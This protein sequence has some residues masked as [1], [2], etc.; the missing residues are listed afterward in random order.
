[1]RR[2]LAEPAP[3]NRR[4]PFVRC[5]SDRIDYKRIAL[6]MTDRIT[7]R[8]RIPQVLADVL[9][10]LE[11]DVPGI[12]VSLARDDNAVFVLPDVDRPPWTSGEGQ[13]EHV[14]PAD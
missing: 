3:W 1:M 7:F 14:T 12:Y 6:E 5:K 2:G 13:T 10:T 11:I 9:G 4:D 8:A